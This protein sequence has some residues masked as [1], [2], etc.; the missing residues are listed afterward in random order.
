M[1]ICEVGG[2]TAEQKKWDKYFIDTTAIIYIV[3]L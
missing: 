2:S 1:T 3:S